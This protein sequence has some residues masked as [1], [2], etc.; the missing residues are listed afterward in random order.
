[1]I[2][3]CCQTEDCCQLLYLF[4][5]APSAG[6]PLHQSESCSLY[7]GTIALFVSL[8][9]W[10]NVCMCLSCLSCTFCC[11]T[12]G[13]LPFLLLSPFGALAFLFGTI[14]LLAKREVY[15]QT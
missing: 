7:F 6:M 5:I 12:F 8:S 2:F 9:V 4:A 13:T 15:H 14:S 11:V 3:C 10:L 1:M